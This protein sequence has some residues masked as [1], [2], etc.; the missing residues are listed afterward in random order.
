MPRGIRQLLL[1]QALQ[2][3]Q[4]QRLQAK[5][6][7]LGE[8]RVGKT[9]LV[10]RFCKDTYSDSQ[11]PTIQ[12]SFLDKTVS[13][14]DSRVSLAIWDTAGQERFHALGPIYYRDADSALLVFDITDPDS[15]IKV[16]SWVKELRKMVGE[17]IILC[18]A[19]NKSDLERHRVVPRQEAADYAVAVGAQYFETSAKSGRGINELFASMAKR[20]LETRKVSNR[21]GS[22]SGVG[23]RGNLLVI[24]DEPTTRSG[25]CC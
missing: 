4:S 3:M 1:L 11:A 24:D 22:G 14:G 17:E 7:L 9:S 2:R 25:G 21:P 10:L 6:V 5:V 23:L 15:F 18:I 19:G 12:A 8:G 13:V 20:L 16:K